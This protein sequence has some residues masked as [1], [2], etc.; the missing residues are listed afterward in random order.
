WRGLPR[1]TRVHRAPGGRRHGDGRGPAQQLWLRE[2]RPRLE[3]RERALLAAAEVRSRDEVRREAHG[4]HDRRDE[5][6]PRAYALPP[7]TSTRRD[8]DRRSGRA[9]IRG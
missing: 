9:E 7:Q 3:G 2:A 6:Q 8:P 5:E 4:R 1:V